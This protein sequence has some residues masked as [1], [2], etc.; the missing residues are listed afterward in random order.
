[1]MSLDAFIHPPLEAFLSAIR[2]FDAQGWTPATSSNFSY[3]RDAQSFAISASGLEKGSLSLH[4]FISCDIATATP[5]PSSNDPRSPSAETLLHATVYEYYPSIHY[6]VH[7]HSS[8]CTVLS[9]LYE[10]Q[11]HFVLQGFE[12]LK[13]L[14]RITTHEARV[15]VPIFSNHQDMTVIRPQLQ[16]A[17]RHA[18]EQHLPLHGFI[19]AGHGLYTWG[20]SPQ[21]AKRHLEVFETLMHCVLE[22]KRHGYP[23]PV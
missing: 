12:L 4:D 17:M 8:P 6:V 14:H 20:R 10:T 19:L 9:K 23:D 7:T 21:E 18:T 3:R 5:L 11:G 22:L 1:M 13:G 16:H 15:T 2:F